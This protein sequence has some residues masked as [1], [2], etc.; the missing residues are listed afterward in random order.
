[1][2]LE[3]VYNPNLTMQKIYKIL[4]PNGQ[5]M[6]SVP[7]IYGFESLFYKQYAYGLQVPEHLHHFSPNTIRYLLNNNGFKVEKILHQNVD[8]DLVA[9]A[10]Y[11][12]NKLLSKL[13]SNKFFRKTFVKVF[14]LFLALIGKTSRMSIY[15]RKIV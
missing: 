9:S 4:K 2:V 14:V 6:I 13:L 10:G 1:M 8:R 15:A 3:H 12:K 7:D 11:M 5:V